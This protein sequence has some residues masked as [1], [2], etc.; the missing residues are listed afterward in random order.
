MSQ[1]S[2]FLSVM[3][4]AAREALVSRGRRTLFQKGST[5]CEQG[6][7]GTMMLLIETGRAQI[8][9]TSDDGQRIVL[10]QLG[11]GDLAGELA[12]LDQAPRSAD[13][14]ASSPV[15]G[16]VLTFSDVKTFLIEHPPIMFAVLVH[17]TAK[18][19][20]ANALAETRAIGDGSARLARCLLRL[21]AR[22]GEG[23][24]P[25]PIVLREQF[26]QSDLG[27]LAGLSR[28]N[29]NR[30]LRAWSKSGLVEKVGGRLVLRDP[31]QLEQMAQAGGD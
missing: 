14:I 31:V 16:V 1:P 25:D 19:R 8:I 6:M 2:G 26:S 17:L 22:W 27:E 4:R 20:E 24:A 21:G 15:T 3:D 18:L 29:V 13:V 30:R 5:I 11:P 7:P 9:A 28:E 23:N 10:G 12:L